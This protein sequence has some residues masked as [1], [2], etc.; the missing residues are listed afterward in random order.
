MVRLKATFLFL[1]ILSG[2]CFNSKMVRL[3][4]TSHSDNR[5]HRGGFQFQNGTIKSLYRDPGN[6]CF[7]TFQ[8]QNGT[9]KSIVKFFLFLIFSRFQFQNGTIK[10][11]L[12]LTSTATAASFNSKMVR[13]KVLIEIFDMR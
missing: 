3:K 8:F 6:T 4:V 2:Q 11:R 7:T 12:S 10:R 1:L 9:I 13:L 5:T